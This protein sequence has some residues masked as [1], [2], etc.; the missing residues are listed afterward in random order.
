MVDISL[1]LDPASPTYGDILFGATGDLVLTSDANPNGTDPVVQL[2]L[3]TLFIFLGEWFMDLTIGIDYFGQILIVN[4]DQNAIDAIF[5]NQ[6]LSVQGVDT[7][8]AYSF[9]PNF[10]TR[11][12]QIAFKVMKTNGVVVSYSG[13]IQG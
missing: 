13:S 11:Q 12:L 10:L 9:T 1:D 7:L 5:I 3:Q 6:I 4:P 8:L 2:I